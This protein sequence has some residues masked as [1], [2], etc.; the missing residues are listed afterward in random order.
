MSRAMRRR[1]G[2]RR[3]MGGSGR[4]AAGFTHAHDWASRFRSETV[5]GVFFRAG[6]QVVLEK[7]TLG[8]RQG[9]KL[10]TRI[11]LLLLL[12]M[13]TGCIEEL[14][15][16]Y[17]R[18]VGMEGGSSVNGT[19]VLADMVAAAGHQV[20]S[21]SSLSPRLDERTD[22][23]VWFP[24]D[25]QPPD[26]E[27]CYWLD[28]WLS[29]ASGRTLIYV[30]R[31]F[32]AAVW[33]WR[34]VGEGLEGELLEKVARQRQMAET[35]YRMQRNNLSQHTGCG[36]FQLDG[37]YRPRKVRTLEGE[38]DW[39][40][41]VNPEGLGIELNGRFEYS[42]DLP[43]EVVLSSEGDA[44]V[45]R[46]ELH[47]SRLLVVTNGSFLLNLPLVNHEHRKLAAKLIAEI[48]PAGQSVAFLESGLGGPVIRGEEPPAGT[49]T[50]M[51]I[52]T[53]WPTSWILLHLAAVGILFCFSRLPIFGRA[54]A[55]P[56][57]VSSDF[58]LHVDAVAR[59]LKRSADRSY[60]TGRVMQYHQTK[61]T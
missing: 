13:L 16:E 55:L 48:G 47:N 19:A 43:A 45:V 1:R 9:K 38:A 46:C 21:W 44:L 37:R 50:G 20:F 27:V 57:A 14:P 7:A 49:P 36:W 23:I 18:R 56:P 2:G 10:S 60:A 31:D 54:R 24:D 22:C 26:G 41:G 58:A 12:L 32:D 3:R 6:R 5:A 15:T 30:G 51:E 29:H 39:L 52:F 25:F 61:T 33:Y 28:D 8:R 42:E 11:S 35:K 59:L 17:G 34:R 4:V 53:V 40:A